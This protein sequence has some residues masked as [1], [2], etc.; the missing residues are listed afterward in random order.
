[1][2][3]W[4]RQQALA[5]TV[6]IG[7]A[8]VA[9]V[10]VPV[11]SGTTP[12]FMLWNPLGSG[13]NLVLGDLTI[14]NIDATTPVVSGL[15]WGYLANAGGTV[16]TGAPVATYTAVTPVNALVGAGSASKA[17]FASAG[18]GTTLTAAIT[19]F[20][21]VGLAHDSTTAGTGWQVAK[22]DQS[23]L[24]LPQGTLISLFGSAA[25]TQNLMPSL[26]WAEV[27]A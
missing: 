9:G 3:D 21:P 18:S 22:L 15:V 12:V 5:G 24:V 26:S 16:A 14:S 11:S 4:F 1:M 6:F 25:Q 20:L 19:T 13:V 8:P 7:S 2:N 17:K 23:P 27:L 10:D